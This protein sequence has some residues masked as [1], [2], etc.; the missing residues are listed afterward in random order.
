[1][2]FS[3][4][5]LIL[6]PLPA[7][8]AFAAAMAVASPGDRPLLFF[9]VLTAAGCV[10]SYGTTIVLFLPSLYLLSARRPATGFTVCLL[11]LVLGAA[12]FMALAVP[13][14]LSSGPDSGPPAEGLLAFLLRWAA[15]P[16]AAMFPGAGLVTAAL[17]WR[18]GARRRSRP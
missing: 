12:A 4:S 11:G 13:A 10:V 7:P 9:L 15:D 16:V 8:L 17:Y 2:R 14:W 5:G 3:W 1:M 18:L 6:A